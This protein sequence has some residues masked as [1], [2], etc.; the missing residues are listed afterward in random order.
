MISLA[1][2]LISVLLLLIPCTTVHAQTIQTQSPTMSSPNS[3]PLPAVPIVDLHPIVKPQQVYSPTQMLAD[4]EDLQRCYPDLITVTSIGQSREG[5]PLIA[6]RLGRGTIP[7]TLNGAHHGREWITSALLMD[8]ID[9]YAL[10]Y[11]RGELIDGFDP[12][13]LLNQASIWIVP[14]VNPDGVAITQQGAPAVAD[15]ISLMKLNHGSMDFSSWKSN[16]RG[17]DLNRQYAADWQHIDNP[18]PSPGP[19][20]YK[21]I[22]PLTEP[23]VIA[24]QQFALSQPFRIHAAFHA[25]GEVIFW[26][27]HQQG[28]LY[29][30]SL[31]IARRLHLLTGYRLVGPQQHESGGGYKDWVVTSLHV[32]AYT[33]EVGTMSRQQAVPLAEYPRI[34][35]QMQSVGLLLAQEAVAPGGTTHYRGYLDGQLVACSGNTASLKQQLQ[36]M[37]ACG[38]GARV[39]IA[40]MESGKTIW[41]YPSSPLYRVVVGGDTLAVVSNKTEAEQKLHQ[42]IDEKQQTGGFVISSTGELITRFGTTSEHQ[43]TC[44]QNNNTGTVDGQAVTLSESPCE[45]KDTLMVPLD[46]LAAAAG[47][48]YAWDVQTA[49]GT[50]TTAGGTVRMIAGSR[51]VVCGD[52]T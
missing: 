28:A 17:V 1:V 31:Q 35:R 24:M 10:A 40:E 20:M 3:F 11:Y 16:A 22:A 27:F 29:A 47:V 37:V 13:A 45:M 46:W 30:R 49:T 8:M 18:A 26:H 34:W 2:L 33:F 44:Q 48:T 52:T 41:Q 6:I 42:Y 43:S 23:E 36:Q 9:H 12:V 15:S 25:A 39:R 4:A 51:L 50:L 14:M 38:D 32:P 7:I 5:R 21:G 19:S